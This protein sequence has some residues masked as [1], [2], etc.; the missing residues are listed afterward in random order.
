[1]SVHRRGEHLFVMSIGRFFVAGFAAGEGHFW[2]APNNAG[3]SW[4]C[5]FELAQRDDGAD[6][7]AAARDLMGCGVLRQTPGR[8]TSRPQLTWLVRAMDDCAALADGLHNVPLL[9]KKAGEFAIWS[10]AVATWR[11]LALGSSRWSRLQQF[12]SELHAHRAPEFVADY[13]RVDITTPEL[14]EFLAGF[15]SAEGHF[16]ATAGGRARFAIK[17]RADDSAVLS[18]LAKRFSVGRLF[19]VPASRHG[20][21][22]TAWIATKLEELRA[23]VRVF[24]RHPP[25]GRAGRIYPHWRHVVMASQRRGPAVKRSVTRMR[26]ARRYRAPRTLPTS[27]APAAVKHERYIATLV[28]W[29]RAAGPPYTAVSYERWRSQELA[30]APTRNTLASFFGS[31]R[32]AL[33]AAG[34]SPH[35]TR[36]PGTNR[37]SLESAAPA[38]AESASRARSAV[39]IAVDRC[40]TVMGKL[41]GAAEFFRWRLENAVDSPGQAQIY[42][43]FPGGWQSVLDQL[44]APAQPIHV[45]PAACEEL[46]AEPGVEAGAAG[47]FGHEGVAGHQVAAGQ[48]Q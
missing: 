19:S 20:R 27:A 47:Q 33:V 29:A 5:G 17:L 7:V 10:R 48:R 46:A 15:A 32:D 1:M 42:R 40:S 8:R 2:I 3:Q 39:L 11:N 25:R 4:S 36:S 23:L 14:A 28:A 44:E 43:L 6:V 30:P 35:G 21:A 24:D 38:R 41:P 37:R 16:G 22:Q 45:A 12:A 13:T 34:L 18:L 9:G 31:W 26:V